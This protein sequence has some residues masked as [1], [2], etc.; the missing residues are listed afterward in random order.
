MGAVYFEQLMGALHAVSWFKIIFFG[1]LTS[2]SITKWKK[3][4]TPTTLKRVLP[5]FRCYS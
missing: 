2:F 5:V 1:V 3:K 4:K